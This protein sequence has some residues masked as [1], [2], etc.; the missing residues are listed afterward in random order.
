MNNNRELCT[1]S[2]NI[3]GFKISIVYKRDTVNKKKP[4]STS[5]LTDPTDQS[6]CCGAQLPRSRLQSISLSFALVE[7]AL[8]RVLTSS[9]SGPHVDNIGARADMLHNDDENLN[10]T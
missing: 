9:Q 5:T 3:C 1:N 10:P 2:K 6:I 4:Q 8:G 7:T